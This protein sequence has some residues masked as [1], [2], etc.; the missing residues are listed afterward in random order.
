MGYPSRSAIERFEAKYIPEPNVGCWLWMAY[1]QRDG[2]GQFTAYSIG[3]RAF[4]VAAHRWSYEHFI[5]PIPKGFQIDHLCRV[6]SCVNPH[7]LEAVT[8]KENVHRGEGRAVTNMHKTH[9]PHGHPYDESNTVYED[10]RRRCYVCLRNKWMI[11]NRRRALQ[12]QFTRT[13]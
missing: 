2:Y 1:L 6:R 8:C 4:Q 13:L 10:G 3:K 12:F 7:H 5:G 11:Q 9:C